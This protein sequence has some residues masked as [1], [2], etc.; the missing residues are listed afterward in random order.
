MAGQQA[1]RLEVTNDGV[2]I[3][4]TPVNGKP[5]G[6]LNKGD[7]VDV[8]DK[9]DDAR[10]KVGKKGEWIK[11]R[12]ADGIEGY[13]S[14][15]FL[16]LQ[17]E[18]VPTTT[19]PAGTKPQET[20]PADTAPATPAP[21]PTPTPSAPAK[22]PA[23]VQPTTTL[24]LRQ[25]MDTSSPANILNKLGGFD[26]LD[27]VEDATAAQAKIG[28]KDQWIKV[29]TQSGQ[30][31]Y[32][33]AQY[34]QSFTG[35]IPQYVLGARN[36]TGMNLDK[37]NPQGHPSPDLMKGIGWIRVKFNV[38]MNPD[39]P[40][41]DPS[42]YGNTDIDAAYNRVKPFIEPYVRAGMKVC[43]V[44]TH[45][46]YGEGAGYVWESMD[47]N[48]WNNL[49]PKFADFARRAAQKFAGSGLVH[50]YQIWNEQDTEQ[51]KGRAAV[52]IPSGD[53]A[54]MLA[55]TIRAIRSVDPT[56]QIISGGHTRG[57]QAG[58]AYARRTIAALPGD[59][60]LDGLAVH[61]YGRGV[62][63]NP[64]SNFGPL[65]ED[66]D[67]M[68]GILPGKPIW[69]TEWG[70]LGFQF[71]DSVSGA[72]ADYAQGFVNIIKSPKYAGKVAAAMWY[73]WADGMDDGYGL[74]NRNGQPRNP[75]YD[76]FLK[77]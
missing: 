61:P 57:P 11:V 44:F 5:I 38:S 2:R 71:N 21:T 22:T 7:I 64:Y 12:E 20:K 9:A 1:L 72:I 49:I 60:R 33:S 46:L 51:G 52:P 8:L 40:D 13:T 4:E 53:Y 23:R 24:N 35:E 65:T 45:Q 19:P 67:T 36:L 43:M 76:R 10:A 62:A 55:Q 37:N 17:T 63:G 16:K 31:G 59:V 58:G 69:Y 74:V 66:L 14:A 6:Q 34:V 15:G 54:N 3:R 39:K 70:A 28:Q 26:I 50:V 77:F 73:A 25:T 75:L 30:E 27:I 42:R 68:I 48:R 47:T 18:N 41:G 56:T 29:R 32:V